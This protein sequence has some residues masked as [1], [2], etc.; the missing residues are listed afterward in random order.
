MLS[1]L[2]VDLRISLHCLGVPV[3]EQSFLFGDSQ[4]V[5][6][7]ATVPQ[8]PLSKRHLALACHHVHKAVAARMLHFLPV[9]GKCNPADVLSKHCGHVQA[10]PLLKPLLF[11]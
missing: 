9:N 6:A 5:I 7:S 4:S 10:C 3:T 2:W 1:W 11:W 8:S